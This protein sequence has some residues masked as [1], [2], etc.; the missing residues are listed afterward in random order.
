MPTNIASRRAATD[1]CWR[2]ASPNDSSSHDAASNHA[3]VTA[4]KAP[5]TAHKPS[6]HTRHHAAWS[7]ELPT[8]RLALASA[9]ASAAAATDEAATA[10]WLPKARLVTLPLVAEAAADDYCVWGVVQVLVWVPPP[11]QVSPVEA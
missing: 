7:G 2:S 4:S 5:G 11:A 8:R 10:S 1:H 9:S 6:V 3:S